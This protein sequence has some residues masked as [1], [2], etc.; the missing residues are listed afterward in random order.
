MRIGILGNEGSWYVEELCRTGKELGHV[1][2]PLVFPSLMASTDCKTLQFVS[3]ETTLHELD[4][5]IVRTMPPGSLERIVTRMDMLCGLEECGVRIV[6]SPKAVECAVDKWLTTQK[7]I[8]AGVPVPDTAVCEDSE[9]AMQ[10]CEQLGGD[11]VVKPLFGSEGRGI[12]RVDSPDLAWRVFRSLER[13]GAVMYL[14]R[15][16]PCVSSD[17]RILLLDGQVIGSM[18][19]T[20]PQGDFRTNASQAGL[21][22]PWTPNED[23]INLAVRAAA[24]TRCVFCGVDVIYD[25]D[26]TAR[27]LEV[28]AVPG[29]RALQ[30]VCD[31]SVPLRLFNW[32][33][34]D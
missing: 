8:S 12:I 28:N 23:E 32:I 11:I 15:F 17:Y 4:A 34:Q 3:G 14:Q 30:K 1:V 22:T 16:I 9:S 18:K 25:S 7:L 13:I 2:L 21:C 6:N 31:V 10:L 27:V 24:A 26:R 19:R 20:A 29:W 5:I 33:T